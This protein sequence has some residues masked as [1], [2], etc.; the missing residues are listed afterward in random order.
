ME[1]VLVWVMELGD[2]QSQ[3]ILGTVGGKGVIFRS[4]TPLKKPHCGSFYATHH[5][6]V[7]EI[8]L[9]FTRTSEENGYLMAMAPTV[10]RIPGPAV[11]EL[12][13][14]WVEQELVGVVHSRLMV[15]VS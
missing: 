3:L 13:P 8:L 1:E 10:L 7:E 11:N 4:H 14:I 15:G 12:L 9:D 2:P 6:R 5:E